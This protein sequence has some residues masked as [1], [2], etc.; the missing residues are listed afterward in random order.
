MAYRFQFRQK[1]SR[2]CQNLG[3][4][5]AKLK[6]SEGRCRVEQDDEVIRCRKVDVIIELDDALVGRALAVEQ[7]GQVRE[8][9]GLKE[10]VCLN[11]LCLSSMLP[12]HLPQ[13]LCQPKR[14]DLGIAWILC[15]SPLPRQSASTCT[16]PVLTKLSPSAHR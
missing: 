1:F 9:Y 3:N 16:G 2:I 6:Q 10:G 14:H 11:F 7:G 15:P 12:T 8:G 13:N 4:R 5:I